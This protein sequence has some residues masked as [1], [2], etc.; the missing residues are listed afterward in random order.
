MLLGTESCGPVCDDETSGAYDQLRLRRRSIHAPARPGDVG[1]GARIQFR[2]EPAPRSFPAVLGFQSP[3]RRH[4]QELHSLGVEIDQIAELFHQRERKL[5]ERA[6]L[7]RCC[8]LHSGE[9]LR[10]GLRLPSAA[11]LGTPYKR[12]RKLSDETTRQP[13][14]SETKKPGLRAGVFLD[15]AVLFTASPVPGAGAACALEASP[16][17]PSPS[18]GRSTLGWLTW[19]S[20]D[21]ALAPPI[22]ET[23]IFDLS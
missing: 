14:L 10:W 1:A 3:S 17:S 11:L 7:S 20:C 19:R 8:E 5:V 16:A 23:L 6:S 9:R 4:R 21:A 18:L 15:Q 2:C 12:S 22:P 13:L